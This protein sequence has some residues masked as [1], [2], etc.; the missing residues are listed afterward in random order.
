[1]GSGYGKRV[2][3]DHWFFLKNM[4]HGADVIVEVVDARDIRATRLPVA[5]KWAGSKRLLVV[6]N[7]ADLLPKGA[8]KPRLENKGLVM[9]SKDGSEDV[10][11]TLMRAIM[12]RT[13]SRPAK[14]LIIG[15]PNVG[16][17]SLINVLAHRQVVRVSPVAGTTKDIQWIRI[18]DELIVSDYRGMFPKHES[19]GEL[20]R[21]GAVKMAGEREKYAYSFA[22]KVLSRPPL[23]KWLERKYDVDLSAAENAEDVL[24]LMAVRRGW[25]LKGGEPNL[26]EAARHLVRAMAEAPEI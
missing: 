8:K 13:K 3:K 11:M 23:R 25:F 7:K 18:N 16:K 26:E 6:A 24:R 5:E 17:S 21:K 14:A 20:V 19:E 15:Y 2:P 22:K 9:S 10:R 4:I 1:M 12:E